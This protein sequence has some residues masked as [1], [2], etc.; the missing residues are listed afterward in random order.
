M[1]YEE[2][3][4]DVMNGTLCFLGMEVR[5]CFGSLSQEV[6][7][8]KAGF[9]VRRSPVQDLLYGAIDPLGDARDAE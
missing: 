9:E 7:N 1:L 8:G 5:C 3:V 6:H 4:Y 2:N